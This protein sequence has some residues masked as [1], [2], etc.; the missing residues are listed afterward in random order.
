MAKWAAKREAVEPVAEAPPTLHAHTFIPTDRDYFR[1]KRAGTL[2]S[3]EVTRI[4]GNRVEFVAL[5]DPPDLLDVTLRRVT[6]F[7]E[8]AERR[9]K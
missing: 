9:A 3:V 2:W 4:D 7:V 1:I 5:L 8:E 6:G